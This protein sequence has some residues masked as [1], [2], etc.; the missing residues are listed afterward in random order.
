MT[1]VHGDL[2]LSPYRVLDLTDERGLL[3]GKILADLGADVIQIEPPGGSTARDIGP[4]YQGEVHPEKSLFWWAY[5]LNKRGIT[6]NLETI[7]GRQLLQRMVQ[8]AH[9]LIESWPPGYL[10]SLGLGYEALA[11]INP[12]LIVV[13]ITPFGQDGPY[14]HYKATDVVGMAMSGL[15][16]LTGD[17]DRAPVRVG[18]P[19]FYLHGAAAGATGAMLAHSARVVTGKG[20]HVDVS[21]QQ[22]VARSL[23]HAPQFWQLENFILKR[24]GA[25]R[26]SAGESKVRVNWRCKDGYVNFMP[27]GGGAG[28]VRSVRSLLAWMREAGQPNEELEAVQWEDLGYG[29]GR[30][31]TMDKTAEAVGAFFAERTRDELVSECAQRRIMLFPVATEHDIYTHPQ[32]EARGYFK[33]IEHPEL[34][35]SVTYPGLFIKDESGERVGLR[36]RPP[37]IGEHNREFYQGELGLTLEALATLTQGKVI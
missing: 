16:Y 22:A 31:E 12:E 5:T 11:A 33:P 37:L 15:M 25:Y 36:R 18:F 17:A 14:A 20:Q 30:A 24:L 29:T 23:A 7:D 13:S 35:A 27:G 28:S 19:Q 10:H 26:Q 34:G 6:L 9:F 3:C 8:D 21:C 4:F 1:G 32:L 2:L